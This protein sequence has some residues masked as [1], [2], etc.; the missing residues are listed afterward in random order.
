MHRQRRCSFVGVRNRS[1]N[2]S[3]RFQ[4]QSCRGFMGKECLSEPAAARKIFTQS[5]NTRGDS[6]MVTRNR[7]GATLCALMLGV[8]GSLSVQADVVTDWN[9]TACDVVA[10]VGPGASGHRMM[11]IVQVA[12]FEAVNSIDPRYVPYMPRGPAAPGASVDAAVAASNRKVLA[13]LMPGEIA[14]IEAAY[15]AAVKKIPDGPSKV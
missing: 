10:K 2:P 8:S 15:E 3:R 7:I 12:V 4:S 5:T 6:P 11:A 14:T 1:S 9:Q 13:A